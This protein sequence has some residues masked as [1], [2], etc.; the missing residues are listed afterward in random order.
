MEAFAPGIS[1][2]VVTFKIESKVSL[3]SYYQPLHETTNQ[4]KPSNAFG[5]PEVSSVR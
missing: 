1:L 3:P 4:L 5:Q 2:Q